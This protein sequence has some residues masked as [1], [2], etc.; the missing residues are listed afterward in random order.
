[1]N[2]ENQSRAGVLLLLLL[3]GAPLCADVVRVLDDPRDAAQA[4]IDIIQQ[5]TKE[6]DAL[7][8]LARND[9]ITMAALSLLRDAR[10]S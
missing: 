3:L 6:I 4:R 10:P 5:A 9:R 8:F 2:A 7:Y 1:M